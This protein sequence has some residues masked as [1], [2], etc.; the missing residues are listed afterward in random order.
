M[1]KKTISDIY[2]ALKKYRIWMLFGWFEIK[3]RYKRSLLGPLWITA[4]LGFM[5]TFMGLLYSQIFNQSVSQ[6]MPFIAC[7]IVIWYFLS[8]SIVEGCRTYIE[9]GEML[10][11]ITLP[12]STYAFQTIW[13]NLIIMGHN[14][15]V[16]IVVFVIFVHSYNINTLLFLPFLLLVAVFLFLFILVI[17]MICARYRDFPQIVQ[18]LMQV[19]MFV[20]PVFWQKDFAAKYWWVSTFNPLYHL[21]ELL[22]APLLQNPVPYNSLYAVLGMT[23]AMFLMA[24]YIVGKYN[25]RVPFWV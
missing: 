9:S 2:E 14:F 16:T 25:K 21:L 24:A 23:V 6:Y 22:R 10:K 18:S 7:S 1:F 5:V 20:T 4:S 13:R 15:L 19:M 3:I 8:Q 12:L 11:Q 17:G